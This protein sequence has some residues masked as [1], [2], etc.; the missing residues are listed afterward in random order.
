MRWNLP[1]ALLAAL[2]LAAPATVQAQGG[3]NLTSTTVVQGREFV[4]DMA[5]LPDGTMFFTEKCRGLS[6]RLP[7]GRNA[8]SQTNSRPCT[9]VALVR[10]GPP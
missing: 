8:M 6:V 2:A 1:G 5:F 4:W 7:S 9:T 3:P 10:F